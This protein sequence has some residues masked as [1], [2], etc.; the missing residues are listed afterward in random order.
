LVFYSQVE[1]KI[2]HCSWLV[3]R[4]YF[5]KANKQQKLCKLLMHMFMYSGA[6]SCS[7]S[8]FAFRI[9]WWRWRW[10]WWASSSSALFSVNC[11]KII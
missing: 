3:E 5:F 6:A 9:G 8:N 1:L 10:W 7:Q 2:L 11:A 4:L